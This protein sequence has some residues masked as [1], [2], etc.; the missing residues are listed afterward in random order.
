MGDRCIIRAMTCSFEGCGRK[1]IARELCTGH[2]QQAKRR[3]ALT[4]IGS[5]KT[6]RAL[7]S[8]SEIPGTLL[9]PLTQGKFA[10]IDESDASAV[11]GRSWSNFQP[12]RSKT[13]YAH[14]F[15]RYEHGKPRTISLHRFLWRE[16]GMPETPE[17][18]H[19]NTN[20]LDC[21]RL[22][23]R[24]AD[25]NKNQH[26]VGIRADNKSGFKGVTWYP[27]YNKW[28]ARIASEGTQRLLGYFSNPADAAKAYAK[29]AAMLHGEFARTT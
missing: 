2:Y 27:K 1:V 16:W 18:D 9:V 23:L 6:P 11:G 14:S 7:L 13:S 3:P 12:P 19:E 15:D 29:S 22:N 10:I 25:G 21:R 17:V 4:P 24:A 5:A 20:G 8:N 28:R 26:N